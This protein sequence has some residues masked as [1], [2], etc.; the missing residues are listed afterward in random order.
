MSVFASRTAGLAVDDDVR[1][2][3]EA[4][5][6]GTAA[7]ACFWTGRMTPLC[8]AAAA[9]AAIGT[10]AC[11]CAGAGAGAGVMLICRTTARVDGGP[12]VS[13]TVER[14]IALDETNTTTACPGLNLEVVAR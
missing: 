2:A 6:C 4:V 1:A 7:S 14:I 11:A 12:L 5:R 8:D 10:R 3:G 9:V 13:C